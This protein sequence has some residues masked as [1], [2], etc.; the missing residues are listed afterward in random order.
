MWADTC[1]RKPLSTRGACIVHCVANA[2]RLTM[3]QPYNIAALLVILLLAQ[4]A[5]ADDSP[6]S[7]LDALHQAGGASDHHAFLEL[8]TEDGSVLGLSSDSRWNAPALTDKLTTYFA[9]GGT[10]PQPDSSRQITISPE[11][12]MAWF[13]ESLKGTGGNTGVGSGVLVRTASGWLVAQYHIS[14]SAVPEVLDS[15]AP[16]A[17]MVDSFAQETGPVVNPA[18]TSLETGTANLPA[19]KNCRKM[20]H[21]TNRSSSC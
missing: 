18:S 19:K 4:L 2:K 14:Y 3:K 1:R 13:S 6:G 10:W 17:V 12:E 20:R 21:K 8:M 16:A 7:A 5:Q 11:G 9:R 15:T